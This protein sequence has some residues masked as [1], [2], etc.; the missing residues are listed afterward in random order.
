M[1]DYEQFIDHPNEPS[2][3]FVRDAL[4]AREHGETEV[5]TLDGRIDV[6][7]D[8]EVIECKNVRRYKDA[9]GQVMCYGRHYPNHVKRIHLFGYAQPSDYLKAFDASSAI[10]IRLT[11]EGGT[12]SWTRHSGPKQRK[13]CKERPPVS[14]EHQFLRDLLNHENGC[15]AMDYIRDGVFVTSS[16]LFQLFSKWLQGKG[17]LGNHNEGSLKQFGMA[18]KRILGEKVNKRCRHVTLWLGHPPISHRSDM[19]S[20]YTLSRER[21][22]GKE[23]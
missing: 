2:E 23:A 22:F 13:P 1:A 12:H 8:T 16:G 3:S 14:V 19:T 5:V 20:C 7:T 21:V 15:E 10:G 18:M 11:V 9:I 17:A 4:A 6:L